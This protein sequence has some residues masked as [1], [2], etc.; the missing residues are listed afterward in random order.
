MTLSFNTPLSGLN[1]ASNSINVVGNNI[2]NANTIGF[3]SGSITFLDVFSNVGGVR[4]NG[5]GNTRQIGDGVQTGAIYTNFSQGNLNESFSPLH[6]AVQGDGFFAVKETDGTAA[7]TRAGDFTVNKNGFLVTPNGA[8][9]QGYGAQNGAIPQDAVLTSVKIPIGQTTQPQVTTNGTQRMNLDSDA[10][11]GATFN[12]TMQVF[13]TKG[14][15][16]NLD[17]TFVRQ[18]NGDY[19]M[20]ATLDGNAA[21]TSENGAALSATPVA[22]SFDSNGGLTNPTSLSIVPDQS[23]LNGAS[24]PSIDINLRTTNPDGSP[25]DFNITGFSRPSAIASI[26]QDGFPAGELKSA[27]LDPSGLVFGVFSNGQ[28]R[29][30]GQYAIAKFNSNEGL[31]R[32]GNN[33]YRETIASGQA[34]IGVPGT[35]GRGTIAGGFLEQSNVNIT[36]EFVELIQAQ[37]SFQANSRVISGLN[38]T[39]QEILQIL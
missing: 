20:T 25:G 5:G 37:R 23:Q 1:A 11:L 24:L 10:L 7:F 39:F 29:I 15:P 14:S 6:A 33:L 2:A 16:R 4:L 8:E 19:N 12:S 21:T 26:A 28:S 34:T 36:N 9:V 31:Q 3:R 30:I 13:D 22:F 17:M 27:A 38:Q 18:A 35:G 32:V